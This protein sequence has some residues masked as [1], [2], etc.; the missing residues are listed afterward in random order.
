MNGLLAALFISAALCSCGGLSSGLTS[1]GALN[2]AYGSL[3]APADPVTI[4]FHR[5]LDT[6]SIPGSITVT[7]DGV[8]APFMASLGESGYALT[9][10][11]DTS[12]KPG[13]VLKISLAGG[14]DGLR[15]TDGHTFSTINLVYYVEQQ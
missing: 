7:A 5:Q 14:A 3:I 9:I 12:W 11:P 4:I 15:Y 8:T 1:S 2:H 10:V 6:A 13:S